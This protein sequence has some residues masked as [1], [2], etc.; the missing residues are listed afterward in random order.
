MSDSANT[1][2]DKAYFD[3]QAPI[4][5]FGG[6]ANLTKFREYIRPEDRVL[7]FGCGGGYLLKN[8]RCRLKAGVEVNPAAA[9]MARENGIEVYQSAA[10][11]P[12]RYVDVIISNHALEHTRHPLNELQS[13]HGKLAENGK[14]VFVVP[15]ES[16]SR[17]YRPDDI[18]FHLYSWSPACIG[19]LFTE[20]G[21]TV[22][23][24]KPYIHKWPPKYRTVAR[25]GGRRLFE[26]GCRIY[27][28]IAR[29]WFQVRVVA[30][31]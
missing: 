15:C 5:E 20:A 3:W 2:Y 31:K 25:L 26:L 28:H 13:L 19:N 6:W 1:H 18:N 9:E 7:D 24:C 29:D 4:G 21:Y 12:D 10:A 14:I 17:S 27:G 30:E 16:I 22:V 8:I 23:E 11:V